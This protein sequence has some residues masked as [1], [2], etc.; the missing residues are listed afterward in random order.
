MLG[1][2]GKSLGILRCCSRSLEERC[3]W[4]RMRWGNVSMTHDP[5]VSRVYEQSPGLG[6]ATGVS[7]GTGQ[8]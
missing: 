1:R 7:E 5:A 3:G 4:Q 2:E 6:L 8:R